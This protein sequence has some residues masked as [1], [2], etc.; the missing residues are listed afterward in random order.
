VQLSAGLC[1]LICAN[2]PFFLSVGSSV[3][4]PVCLIISPSIHTQL[5]CSKWRRWISAGPGRASFTSAISHTISSPLP[6]S[7]RSGA[8]DSFLADLAAC[9][10][11][12]RCSRH[13][14]DQAAR[15]STHCHRAL[16]TTSLKSRDEGPRVK[17]S[18]ISAHYHPPKTR[19]CVC[20]CAPIVFFFS[21]PD[22]N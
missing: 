13:T 15:R 10:P 6:T 16:H 5:H 3:H 8:P 11:H 22:H 21:S 19:H 4:L 7:S 20:M 1:V 17:N 2:V 14:A 9:S 12:A 18:S